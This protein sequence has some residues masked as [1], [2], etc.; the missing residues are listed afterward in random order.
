MKVYI[1][2]DLNMRKGKMI[3]QTAHAIMALFLN[4]MKKEN[5]TYILEGNNFE[6]LSDWLNDDLPLELIKVESEE[7]LIDF[8]S[9]TNNYKVMIEDQGRTEFK[10]S[11]TKTCFATISGDFI[12][13]ENTNCRS[14]DYVNVKQ[15][16]V[17]NNDIKDEK[18]DLA[19]KG[20]KASLL[21]LLNSKGVYKTKTSIMFDLSENED[22]KQ[23]LSGAFAKIAV[24]AD[25]EYF[26]KIKY[27]GLNVYSRSNCLAFSP[28]NN[29]K[30]EGIT[31]DLKLI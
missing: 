12:N 24:K 25:S 7:S 29:E 16:I 17:I 9:K 5:D 4:A 19:L 30:Y 23:W 15:V 21:A 8:Y 1:R 28:Y 31:S 27:S 14:Y 10:G 3:A 26:E 13:Y 18:W 11:P 2:K 6:L 22:L 20:A